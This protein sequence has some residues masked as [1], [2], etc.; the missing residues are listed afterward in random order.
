[1][2]HRKMVIFAVVVLTLLSVGGA[3]YWRGR[4]AI[5]RAEQA[6]QSKAYPAAAQA[7]LQALRYFPWRKDLYEKAGTA[8][9]L[10]GNYPQAILHLN[11]ASQLSE[12]GWGALA[13]AYLQTNEASAALQAYQRGLQ[14]FPNSASLYSGLAMMYRAQADWLDE[15]K[16]LQNQTRLDE[17]N[18]YAH[19]RLGLLWTLLN[20]S[21]AF[22]EFARASALDPEFDSATQ[23]LIAALNIA[24]T[25]TDEAQKK[26]T[27]GRALGL[28][29]EWA[30]AKSAFEQALKTDAENAEAWAW[31]GEAEQQLGGDGGAELDRALALD[32]QSAVVRAL[33]GLRWNRLQKYNQ[34]LA[35]YSLAARLEPENPAWQAAIGD[36]HLKRGDLAAAIGF[37]QRAAELTPNDPTYWRLLA[38]LCA[39]QGSAVEE[40]GLPAAQKAVE[41]APNDP[42]ALDALG[43][44]YFSSGRYASAETTLLAA[45]KIAPQFYAAHVHLALNDLAQGDRAGAYNALTY[46]RDADA[47]GADG[48]RARQLLAQYFP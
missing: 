12:Q 17:T 37:Y 23:T 6:W 13:Y 15:S 38:M 47:N 39:E 14:N 9:A 43:F 18:A 34:M 22:A 36:A 19:Y 2:V 41:L 10:A 44:A 26:I 7:Y 21:A 27:I 48:A 31:L 46:V 8:Q 35:E 16:A 20:P 28:T 24:A 25:Q 3:L 29:Q 30:L 42:L 11:Q 1:M 5:K 45:I 4:S 33:R 40:L 32:S